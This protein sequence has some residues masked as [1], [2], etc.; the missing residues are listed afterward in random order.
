M[1][2]VIHSVVVGGHVSVK[3]KPKG[4]NATPG[5]TSGGASA[6]GMVIVP[7]SPSSPS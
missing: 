5:T 1:S 7:L 4:S 6:F 3:H 2:S